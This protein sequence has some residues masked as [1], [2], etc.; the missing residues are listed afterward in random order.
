MLT[1]LLTYLLIR[2]V[3]ITICWKF[4]GTSSALPVGLALEP[5][6]MVTLVIVGHLVAGPSSCSISRLLVE[7]N[8]TV[9]SV[10]TGHL[11]QLSHV[12]CTYVIRVNLHTQPKFHKFKPSWSVD[13]VQWHCQHKGSGFI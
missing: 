11:L 9:Q 3:I 12:W 1:Y 4:E 5:E 7:L 8:A 10:Q 6:V 2:G 13:G